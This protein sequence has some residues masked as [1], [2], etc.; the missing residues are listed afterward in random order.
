MVKWNPGCETP[1]AV[2]YT[3]SSGGPFD[4][5]LVRTERGEDSEG[6]EARDGGSE[7][8]AKGKN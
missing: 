1:E 2:R 8:N 3:A 5:E 7:G 6:K 4:Q